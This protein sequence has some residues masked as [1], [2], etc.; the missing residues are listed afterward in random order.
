MPKSVYRKFGGQGRRKVE[1]GVWP[2]GTVSVTV[3]GL[4]PPRSRFGGRRNWSFN[5]ND[6]R[7]ARTTVADW[8]R[9]TGL[10]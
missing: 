10:S 8:S 6:M 9:Q 1:Y 3:H 7:E 4:L 2:D 5:A